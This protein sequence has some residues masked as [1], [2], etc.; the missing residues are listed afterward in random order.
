M[1]KRAQVP[2]AHTY[3]I[4][5]RGCSENKDSS[6]ALEKVLAIYN[7]MFSDKCPV[8]PSTIHVN[9]VL[10]MCSKAQ[11][12]D[13]MF[14]IADHL[15]EKGLRAPNNLTYTTILNG[16]RMKLVQ[17]VRG[18]MT[19]MQ[20]RQDA[21]NSILTARHIW[22]DI[23]KRWRK[24]D[25][26]IDEELVCS[27]GR[28]L[29]MGNDRDADDVL[30]L[31]EQ[32]MSI[33]RQTP[34][35]SRPIPPPLK[36]TK[37]PESTPQAEDII[38]TAPSAET[39]TEQVTNELSSQT[40]VESTTE[41]QEEELIPFTESIIPSITPPKGVSAFPIPAQNTLSLIMAALLKLRDHSS[42]KKYWTHL[43]TNG[44]I[45]DGENY[46]AYL[47]TLRIT[48]ASSETV[49]ILLSMPKPLITIGTYRI[50]IATCVRDKNNPHAFANA[51]KILDLMQTTHTNPDPKVLDT[52]LEVAITTP[53]HVSTAA[54]PAQEIELQKFAHGA[55]I[56]RALHRLGPAVINLKAILS[57]GDENMRHLSN[58]EREKQVSAV[59]ALT[60][61]MVSAYDV[62][63]DK[64][65]V[66]RVDYVPLSQER[67]KLTAFITRNKHARR[68]AAEA[69]SAPSKSSPQ[70]IAAMAWEEKEVKKDERQPVFKSVYKNSEKDAE[71]LDV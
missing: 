64:G 54:N 9:A 67:N 62:L 45:P 24:G 34:P 44:V 12:M 50:A 32:S 22:S 33:P 8:K 21:Q 39:A 40:K 31:I 59:L 57:F 4:I 41:P 5:F 14:A 65:M 46:N 53:V 6:Q 16:L 2:D 17:S 52:Y 43:I 28:L 61:R 51:G 11:N 20:Q 47:R 30:S 13:A 10:K 23:V 71:A 55:Q 25:I 48:R 70:K 66:P 58:F 37:E 49:K 69:K 68:A 19:S 38:E 63:M 3:T 26:W 15:P 56:S 1:K 7:S 60:Q 42:P 27:M 35:K 29:L 18:D 36:I